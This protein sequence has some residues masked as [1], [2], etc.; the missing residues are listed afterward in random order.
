M[1]LQTQQKIWVKIFFNPSFDID[2]VITVLYSAPLQ[3]ILRRLVSAVQHTPGN[4]QSAR[5]HLYGALLYFL[6]VAKQHPS[7]SNKQKGVVYHV[8]VT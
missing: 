6:M 7:E 8:I 3:S 4:M 5:A 2:S 1:Q